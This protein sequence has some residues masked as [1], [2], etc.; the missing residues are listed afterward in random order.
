MTYQR[1]EKV[2]REHLAKDA[3]LYVRQSTLRQ[4]HENTE[5]TERQYALRQ[6]AVALGWPDERIHVIDSDL[7]RSAAGA[8]DREGFHRLVADVGMG[9]A[10]IVMGLE[11]SRLARRCS[12]WHHLLEIC[13]LTGTLI[14]DEDGLYDP[15]L[16]NDRLVLG[17]KGT[18]SE[19]ELYVIRSRLRGGLLNK[20]RRG[21]LPVRLP[22]GFVYDADGKVLLDP[23]VQVQQ[24]IRLLFETFRRTGAAHAT[25]KAFRQEGLKFPKRV[26]EGP[27]AG[28][29]M[30]QP[31]TESRIA[32]ILHNP[33][34]AGAFCYGRR[35]LRPGADGR[36]RIVTMPEDQWFV[37][38]PDA[39]AAYISW[40]EYQRVQQQLADNASAQ[41]ARRAYVPREGPALLQGLAVCGVCGTHMSVRYHVRHGH[42]RVTYLCRGMSNAT[43][44]PAC[45]NIPGHTI[46]EAIGRLLLEVMTPAALE[47][48]LAVQREVEQR[49]EETDSLRRKEVERVRYEAECARHRY[50]KVDPDNR[51]VADTLEAQWNEKL[52]LLR[53]AENDYSRRREDDRMILDKEKQE[54]ILT[55][56]RDFPALWRDPSLPHRERK[57]MVALLLQDVTLI[58]DEE[59]K[60]DVR[61]KGGAVRRLTAPRTLPGWEVWRTP[62]EVRETINGLLSDNT[63]G[64]IAAI[65]NGRGFRSG[66]GRTFDGRRVGA[67]QREYGM[68]TR[69][70]RLRDAGWITMPDIAALLG[71]SRTTL[72]KRRRC[73]ILRL[74]CCKLNDSGQFM[75]RRPDGAHAQAA[76]TGTPCAEE[77]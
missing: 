42:V 23:D 55:L 58:K 22:V 77:V 21:E 4:V 25:V 20:A 53:E 5:S 35:Q 51:L 64:E 12:D 43:A 38:I 66:Q 54:R 75:Y 27:R 6:R 41:T 61:F 72:R 59:I 31:L 56:A 24:S 63:Q 70:A 37:L 45:Q 71:I 1:D 74:E 46:D 3:Y 33:S 76:A 36:P 69:R 2:T 52:R 48:A 32:Q 68:K 50:M 15:R 40:E 7:G 17:L 62:L 57:R 9:R 65:L 39:H 47:L 29:L 16:F 73:G 60:I 30:W 8:A 14:L 19:A 26:H 18:M 49:F 11:V 67:I 34:Y 10:G 44:L 28:E 13:A